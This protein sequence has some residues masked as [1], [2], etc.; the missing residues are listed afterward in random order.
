MTPI[1]ASMPFAHT[2]ALP[3]FGARVDATRDARSDATSDA[4][5]DT[6]YSD[7]APQDGPLVDRFRRV[8]RDLRLSIT[9]RCNFRCTYCLAP[10]ARFLAKNDLLSTA[11]LIRVGRLFA[12]LGIERLRVTGG[13]PSVHP[14]LCEILAAL[15]PHFR[16]VSM[17]TNGALL[18]HE[19][20]HAWK[21]AGLHRIT[22]SI[23]SLDPARFRAITRSNT[24]LERVLAGL[25]AAI[26]AGLSPVKVN[27]V[28]QGGVN[29]ADAPALAALARELDLDVRFIEFMPLDAEHAWSHDAVVASERALSAIS[30]RFPLQLEGRDRPDRT[31]V[32]YRFA[33]G[34]KG[35][36]GTIA[37]VSQPF[38]SACSRVRV[39]ADGFIRPCLL[40]QSE[41]PLRELL[42]SDA[43]D[44]ALENAV[45]HAVWN[46]DSGGAER[47][48]N[49]HAVK[50]A[51]TG[52][53]TMS[54]IGG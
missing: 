23:D 45:R 41:W 2:L 47:L 17:T 44:D 26:D 3:Q 12:R 46:K 32:R 24:S 10:D 51:R 6:Q 16:D 35:S 33:D 9:D 11:Q 52:E 1:L 19:T 37:P 34:G 27:A 5:S 48:Q 22:I 7:A 8:V 40:S 21:D 13:E 53:R 49:A 25:A 29:D 18:T 15:S 54:A 38:C 43:S 14:D 50:R 42:Q 30:Q 20:A 36:V 28:L 39:T 31:A 4:V